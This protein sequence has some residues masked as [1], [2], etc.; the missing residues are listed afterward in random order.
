LF[1]LAQAAPEA[2][3][4]DRT[5]PLGCNQTAVTGR[6]ESPAALCRTIV[7]GRDLMEI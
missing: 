1:P 7:V 3:S 4:D 5:L 6:V 2:S